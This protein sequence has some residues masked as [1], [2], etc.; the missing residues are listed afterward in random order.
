MLPKRRGGPSSHPARVG[1]QVEHF[2]QPPVS[3][4]EATS[5]TGSA[6][7]IQDQAGDCL[8]SG[9]KQTSTWSTQMSRVGPKLKLA[10]RQLYDCFGVVSGCRKKEQLMAC[11]DRWLPF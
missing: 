10:C 9:A 2:H 5:A 6:A 7:A 3:A 4:A 8:L 1:T 11:V